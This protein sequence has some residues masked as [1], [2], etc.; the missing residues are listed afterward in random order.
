LGGQSRFS[1]VVVG[2]VMIEKRGLYNTVWGVGGDVPELRWNG[3]TRRGS[4]SEFQTNTRTQHEPEAQ[5][6][7]TCGF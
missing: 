7:A 6:G 2:P 3:W 1:T 5:V 4:G